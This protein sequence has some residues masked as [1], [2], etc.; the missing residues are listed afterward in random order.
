[1]IKSKTT[2]E[3]TYN[4]FY[5]HPEVL[6]NA[7]TNVFNTFKNDPEEI[8]LFLNSSLKNRQTDKLHNV[9]KETAEDMTMQDL[10]S[11]RVD[12]QVIDL[13]NPNISE[14]ALDNTPF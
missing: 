4:G 10:L 7:L 9:L 13:S 3:I 12:P 11:L 8:A 5:T 14:E 2:Y 1:M 6:D